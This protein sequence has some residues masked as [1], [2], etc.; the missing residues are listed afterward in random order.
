MTTLRL[1]VLHFLLTVLMRVTVSM[2]SQ[3]WCL[4]R[5]HSD[6]DDVH[7]W[8][9]NRIRCPRTPVQNSWNTHE[10]NHAIASIQ[11][12]LDRSEREICAKQCFCE[13]W[14]Y[15]CFPGRALQTAKDALLETIFGANAT[16]GDQVSAPT[17]V[18]SC[19]R[20]N[21]LIGSREVRIFHVSDRCHGDE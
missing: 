8:G 14:T 1:R 2:G 11:H 6:V 9:Q 4:A 15:L 17:S 12:K 21:D 18:H 20:T 10:A 19:S 5:R 16:I 3:T 13:K 7:D